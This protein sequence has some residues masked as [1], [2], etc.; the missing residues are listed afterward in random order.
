MI[1]PGE[2][3]I[4]G[5]IVGLLIS[6]PFAFVAF[7][8]YLR[9]KERVAL[10]KQGLPPEADAPKGGPA[11]VQWIILLLAVALALSCSLIT[12]VAVFLFFGATAGPGLIILVT[13]FIFLVLMPVFFVA[14]LLII[15]RQGT[16]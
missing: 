3:I 8:R 7:L 2:I 14:A 12:G 10:A 9:Y 4:I 5:L 1:G 13:P 15:R 11:S 16:K 6:V